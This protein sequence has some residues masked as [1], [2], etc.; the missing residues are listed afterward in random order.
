LAAATAYGQQLPHPL[1]APYNELG[2][3]PRPF[4][5]VPDT[6]RV[7]AAMVQFQEDDDQTTTGNGRFDLSS[8]QDPIIDAPPHNGAFFRDHLTFAGNYFAKASDGLQVI[9]TTLIDTVYTLPKEMGEYSPQRNESNTKLAELARDA[10][11][12]VGA[13]DRVADFSVYDCF[14]IFHAG[15]GRDIDLVSLLGY[16]PTP[17]DI[18]SIYLG[19]GA[20]REAFGEDYPGIVVSN[21]QDTIKNSAL[22][23]ETEN[24]LL[25]G[26]SGDILLELSF[27]GLLCA[28]IGSYLGLPDLFDTN[29]GRSGIGRFG[30]MDGQSIFS[31]AGL[32]PPEPS[33]WEKY[34][35]GWI[36]PLPVLPDGPTVKL[37]AVGL[38]VPDTVLRVPIGVSEYYLVENRQ[39]DPE[40]DGQVVSYT[41]NGAQHTR[42]FPDDTVGFNAF[43]VSLLAG[44]VTDVQN[45]D[46]S[47]PGGVDAEG[48]QLNG[49][50]LIWH[51]DETVIQ[52]EIGTNSVNADPEYRGVD[53]EEADGSQDIGQEYGFLSGGSGSEE[54]TPLDYW[55]SGNPA[56]VYKNEFDE[57]SFPSSSANSG[58][59]SLVSVTDISVPGPIMTLRVTVGSDAVTPVSGFPRGTEELLTV[60]SLTVG[61]I[62]PGGP[63][64][65]FATTTG[66]RRPHYMLEGDSTVVTGLPGRVLGWTGEGSAVL[67]FLRRD[68]TV[69]QGENAEGLAL[70]ETAAALADLNGDAVQE[71]V[72]GQGATSLSAGGGTIRATLRAASLSDANGDSLADTFFALDV[73]RRIT[74]PPAINQPLIA[75]GA[76]GGVVYVVTNQGVLVDSSTALADA[77]SIVGVSLL[78]PGGVEESRGFLVSGSDGSLAIWRLSFPGPAD[79]TSTPR[80]LGSGLSG[81]AVAGL[82]GTGN[83]RFRIA[84]TTIDGSLF[85][86]DSLLN[87]QPGFPVST[88]EPCHLPPALADINGDGQLDIIVFSERNVHVYNHLGVSLDNFPVAMTGMITSP[89]VAGDVDGDG[90]VDIVAVTDNGFVG[91]FDRNGR[92]PEGFPLQSGPGKQ[93]V[94]L[95]TIPSPSLSQTGLAVAVG[96]SG[97]GSVTAWMTGGVALP[98]P[99]NHPWPQFLR[100]QV[101]SGLALDAI[102]GIPVSD[103][104]FPADRAYNWPNPVYGGTTSI[105]FFV[106]E[107]AAVHVT[108]FDLAGDL[109]EELSVAATG[110]V[111]NEVQWDVSGVQSGVYFAR[112][113][114]SGS[115]GSG[116]ALI[117]VA[118]VK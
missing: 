32:F 8:T 62:D 7:L 42:T 103:A 35:L 118:V 117:K 4:L 9:S 55:Y 53:V 82:F 28:S 34:W 31:F 108:I 111:D 21:G 97:D 50:L 13:S 14:V 115:G 76:T 6:V 94:A 49:G 41:F 86:L 44:V 36:A 12:A 33:A 75:A 73:P 90:D 114:A 93:S 81:P 65:W 80:Q 113:E 43:D 26:I 59:N 112:I 37:P 95:L 16:D 69:A 70:F 67:P 105:R 78:P 47:L 77:D 29:T 88:G 63:P 100:D 24:R 85:L 96:S 61:T 64:A 56:P 102:T 11:T 39:R 74:T 15:T 3:G 98:N 54:G 20:F 99:V 68:G 101:H 27:N 38:G 23:P 116:S 40:R 91:A 1:K 83:R 87:T 46:W 19:M 104:F 58:S 5:V 71:L 66:K 110:G 109:V 89:P 17:R 45:S 52:R 22:L 51:I 106:K 92:M 2:T 48:T 18:P 72:L 107:D 10:W 25:P 84:A 57:S 60:P 79:P 30:L